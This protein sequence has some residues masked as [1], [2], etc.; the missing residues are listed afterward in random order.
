MAKKK[1]GKP[2]ED[3]PPFEMSQT[4]K[5]VKVKMNRF[6]LLYSDE[7]IINNFQ[8]AAPLEPALTS[9]VLEK[10]V[11]DDENKAIKKDESAVTTCGSTPVADDA[12]KG[13]SIIGQSPRAQ[14]AVQ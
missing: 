2:K 9:K 14:Q 6:C 13:R 12:Y 10:R 5:E 1:N 3:Y 11:A 4:I 7:A 8:V